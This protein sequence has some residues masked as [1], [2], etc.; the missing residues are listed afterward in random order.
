MKKNKIL[1]SLVVVLWFMFG[2]WSVA[3]FA[4]EPAGT[5]LPGTEIS[6]TNCKAV[7]N[8]V[9]SNSAKVKEAFVE[10][11]NASFDNFDVNVG[12]TGKLKALNALTLQ[13]VLACGIKTGDIHLWMIPYY[14][15]YILEFIIGIA[16]LI[17]VGSIVYGG[18]MYLFS[19]L[20]QDKDTGK[21]AILYGIVG[22]ILTLVAWAFVNIIIAFVTG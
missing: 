11:G 14:I 10:G 22:M 19:G 8:Y 21:K 5:V 3:A 4:G 17:A 16:G 6:T 20:S 15:R 2:I 1:V 7:M 18:Y 9:S 12:D 13:D